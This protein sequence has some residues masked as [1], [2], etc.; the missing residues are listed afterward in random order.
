MSTIN[1]DGSEKSF[2]A[3][4]IDSPTE[5]ERPIEP[6]IPRG[7]LLRP[8]V[9]PTDHKSLPIEKLLDFVINRWPRPAIRVRDILR[10]GPPA[11]RNR[12]NAIALAETLAANGWLSELPTRRHD[13]KM[14]AII[15][16]PSKP[17]A[18]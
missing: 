7:P 11:A 17:V 9:P 8:I 4:Y 12:K 6:E 5:K 16:E 15:R 13:A 14:W 3:R 1:G 18:L 2:F 10:F